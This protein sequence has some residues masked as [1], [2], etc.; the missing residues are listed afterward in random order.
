MLMWVQA[1]SLRRPELSAVVWAP[2]M[3]Q[4]AAAH[5]LQ[6]LQLELSQSSRL[7]P[8]VRWLDWPTHFPCLGGHWLG[9]RDDPSGRRMM[10]WLPQGQGQGR[11]MPLGHQVW[12]RQLLEHSQVLQ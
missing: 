8:V 3:K 7:T 1:A 10:L 6:Q 9:R 4:L 2:A 11:A 12:H 5:R